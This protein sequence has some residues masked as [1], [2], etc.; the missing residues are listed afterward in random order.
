[1]LI[2]TLQSED[3]LY[4]ISFRSHDSFM[5]D[6]SDAIIVPI[7]RW[8]DLGKPI[9]LHQQAHG[10]SV[11]E[12]GLGPLHAA[13]PLPR[14]LIWKEEGSVLSLEAPHHTK[15]FSCL[16]YTGSSAWAS[17]KLPQRF[18]HCWKVAWLSPREAW[19]IRIIMSIWNRKKWSPRER[20]GLVHA[21]Q[22]FARVH[23][24]VDTARP[25]TRWPWN[26]GDWGLRRQLLLCPHR[27]HPALATLLGNPYPVPRAGKPAL[28][29][30]AQSR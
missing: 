12:Q 1:M 9:N 8:R 26:W 20:K 24:T 5:K 19:K 27:P 15:D 2:W 17:C 22:Q 13:P 6:E 29:Q 30:L 10:K 7:Y 14:V 21:A 28:T 23:F 25:W 3:C 11:M 16:V 4:M 18:S